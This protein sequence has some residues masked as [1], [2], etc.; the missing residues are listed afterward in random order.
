MYDTHKGVRRCYI[1]REKPVSLHLCAQLLQL[2]VRHVAWVLGGDPPLGGV[3]SVRGHGVW[4]PGTTRGRVH[5][6]RTQAHAGGKYQ[7]VGG[8]EGP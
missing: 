6:A 8:A 5:G 3:R 2:K 1:P 4:A 7:E